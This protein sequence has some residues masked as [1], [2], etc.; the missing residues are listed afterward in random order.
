[1]DVVKATIRAYYNAHK[2]DAGAYVADKEKSPYLTEMAKVTQDA[3]AKVA[4][5][6]RAAVAEGKKPAITLDADDTTVWT[7]DMEEAMEFSF[8]P[9]FQQAYLEKNDMPATPGMVKLVK[10]AKDAGCEIIGLTGRST[11]Q[12]AWTLRNLRAVGYTEFTDGLYFT[13]PSSDP[14]KM[15]SY[16][17][18]AGAKCTTVEFKAGTRAHI[19]KDLGYTIVG[20]FG[21]QYSD[22]IGGH[23]DT[24][25]K[26]PNP[27]YYLP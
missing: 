12:K 23:S 26:L 11:S 17:K 3:S 5:A 15:P 4:Q 1:M 22:L 18:C 27:T 20:N 21:D 10:V 24:A 25:Y 7:Y 8:T 2:N 19:E 14:A 16:I 13:K 6:C 9:Q